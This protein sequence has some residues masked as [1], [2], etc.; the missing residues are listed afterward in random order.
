VFK[1]FDESNV[2]QITCSDI[3]ERFFLF[4]SLFC[5]FVQNT[6]FTDLSG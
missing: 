2:F 3:T 1:R 4:L 6:D 5:V